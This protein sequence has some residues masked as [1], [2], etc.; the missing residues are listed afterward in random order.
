MI[1]RRGERETATPAGIGVGTA[2]GQPRPQRDGDP[3]FRGPRSEAACDA[4]LARPPEEDEQRPDAGPVHAGCA[5]EEGAEQ[6]C[7]GVAAHA[8]GVAERR[9]AK[10]SAIWSRRLS[11]DQISRGSSKPDLGRRIKVFQ[12]QAR[13]RRLVPT[14]SKRVRWS[15]G[16]E[17]FDQHVGQYGTRTSSGVGVSE[18]S[19]AQEARE[20]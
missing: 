10:A 11:R 4:V 19:L 13:S 1:D 7:E 12:G 15:R 3:K 2:R 9:S 5:G 8:E 18:K 14:G 16:R 20:L 6:S 17:R